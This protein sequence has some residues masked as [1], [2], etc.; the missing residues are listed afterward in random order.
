MEVVRK[1]VGCKGGLVRV[2]A[3]GDKVVSGLLSRVG[4][5]GGKV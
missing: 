1:L 5:G 4:G 3:W 2:D